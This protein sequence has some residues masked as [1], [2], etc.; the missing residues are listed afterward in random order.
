MY[1][2]PVTFCKCTSL[3]SARIF[4][5]HTHLNYV[6]MSGN[7]VPKF[8][9]VFSS[10]ISECLQVIQNETLPRWISF[11]GKMDPNHASTMY[12]PALVFMYLFDRNYFTKSDVWEYDKKPLFSPYIWYFSTKCL[13]NFSF[14][15]TYS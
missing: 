4:I 3:Q 10:Y 12:T 6:S 11:S 7:N 13:Q 14:W 2:L 8:L 5:V 1:K 9:S 15:E